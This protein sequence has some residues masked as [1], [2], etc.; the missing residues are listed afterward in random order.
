MDLKKLKIFVLCAKYQSFS[1]V[2]ELTYMSQSA[3]SKSIATL[4]TEVG[5]KLFLRN[6]RRI[7]LTAL[8]TII[9]PY[10]EELCKM[11]DDMQQILHRIRAGEMS[12][13]LVI[14]IA[15]NLINTPVD[16]L[17]TQLAAGMRDLHRLTICT[18]IKVVTFVDEELPSILGS[19][20]VQLALMAVN[21]NYTPAESV[22]PGAH[23]MR[24]DRTPLFL[25][26]KPI[27]DIDDTLE[28]VLTHL[29]RILAFNDQ[30]SMN[31]TADFMEK[32]G[33]SLP[34]DLCDSWFSVILRVINGE[35]GAIMGLNSAQLAIRCGCKA[36]GLDEIGITASLVAFWSVDADPVVERAAEVL[37]DVFT[38]SCER[39]DFPL[40]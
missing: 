25:L 13:P 19:G 32:V 21:N 12:V 22:L 28:S 35:C 40:R 17:L 9:L 15:H 8:G 14:G 31:S 24:L 23:S 26:Y 37:C 6:T 16:N 34:F 38:A 18:D 33:H 4:E 11:D 5:G 2:A 7:D 1:R 20:Q 29:P 3:I 27:P 30:I 10:A 36:I 39:L